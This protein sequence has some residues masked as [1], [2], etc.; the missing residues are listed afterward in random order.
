M[1][2]A[3]IERLV[4]DALAEDLGQSGDVT[5]AAVIPETAQAKA[6]IRARETGILAGLDFALAAF[7]HGDV[8][9]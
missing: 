9:L 5:S 4:A 7:R 2:D 1:P 6:V 3:I 8:G